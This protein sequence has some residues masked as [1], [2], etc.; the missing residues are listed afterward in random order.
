MPMIPIRTLVMGA[1]FRRQRP[2]RQPGR[3]VPR[4]SLQSIGFVRS[5][6]DAMKTTF[7]FAAVFAMAASSCLA[8]DSDAKTRIASATKKLG[9]QPNYSWTTSTKEADGSPGRISNIEGKSDKGALTYLSFAVGGV[10]VEVYLKGTNGAAKALESWM[11]LDEIA[12]SGGTAA[13]IVRYLRAYKTPAAQSAELAA[14]IRE[15]KEEDGV[16]VAQLD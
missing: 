14:S 15:S 5:C 9:E 16:L 3:K 11:T 12:Q 2:K 1:E 13:A 6:A 4:M 7:F 8:A 10:P